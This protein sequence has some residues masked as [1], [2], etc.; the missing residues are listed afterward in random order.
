MIRYTEMPKDKDEFIWL[1]MKALVVQGGPS[2]IEIGPY[3]GMCEYRGAED[4]ACAVGFWLSEE[5]AADIQGLS[6]ECVYD[7]KRENLP[8]IFKRFDEQ[9]TPLVD[10]QYF[11]DSASRIYKANVLRG[12]EPRQAWYDALYAEVL[13]PMYVSTLTAAIRE[14]EAAK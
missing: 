4:R 12:L 13:D 10:M 3:A 9:T 5:E 6:A 1:T 8:R 11:H 7:G 2:V 14:Y